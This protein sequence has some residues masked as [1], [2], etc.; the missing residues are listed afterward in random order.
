MAQD[1]P[2]A[3]ANITLKIDGKEEIAGDEGSLS[4]KNGENIFGL[5]VEKQLNAPNYFSVQLSM[6][7][8]EKPVFLDQP[9]EGK[10]VEI[11]IGYEAA[12]GETVFKGEISYVEP[13]FNREGKSY[14]ELSGFD[15]S[16]RLTR[17]S[18]S[19]VWGDG[20]KQ[21][22]KA[23]AMVKEMVSAS[24]DIDGGS[25]NLAPGGGATSSTQLPYVALYNTNLF[26]F[27]RAMGFDVAADD[28]KAEKK[29][30][31]QKI[32]PSKSPI[33]TVCREREE[34]TAPALSVRAR[35]QLSTIR[36]Y[37]KVVV[38]GW[39]PK[40]KKAIVGEATS[41]DYSF[42]GK[43]GAKASGKAHYG[44]DSTGK[45]YTVV[46][47]PVT[48]KAEAEGLA[49]ALFNRFSM[50]FVTG[51]IEIVGNTK[52]EPGELVELKQFGKRFDGKYL[53]G[54]CV[55]SYYPEGGG[56]R[57]TLQLSRNTQNDA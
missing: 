49:K 32:E 13:N 36:Q 12:K 50:D 4:F 21:A 51:E 55:H 20:V 37:K 46:D 27:A 11:I 2:N 26:Q 57:T 34:G 7:K 53:I 48:S 5:R 1:D 24:G 38:K 35:F 33:L 23:D 45:V 18:F 15:L 56:Y 29:I 31:F 25:D 54:A 19:K 8:D 16:H 40:A 17:G 14:L 44:S 10:P 28:R 41:S 47:Q 6:V 39:D 43:D 3:I 42:G 22:G 30:L 52:A 9:L